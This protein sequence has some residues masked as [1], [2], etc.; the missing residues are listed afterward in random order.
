D[1]CLLQLRFAADRSQHLRERVVEIGE[2][3][4][5]VEP[6]RLLQHDRERQGIRRHRRERELHPTESFEVDR[7]DDL[8]IFHETYGRAVA[9]EAE[10]KHPHWHV[11][12]TSASCSTSG[13]LWSWPRRSR[14]SLGRLR[15]SYSP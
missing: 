7:R 12:P 15:R 13:M 3:R 6:E 8:A 1:A 9:R 14:R 4:D 11:L 5:L 2:R 10:A